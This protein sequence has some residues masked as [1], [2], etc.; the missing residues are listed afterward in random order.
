M[1]TNI[2]IR[3]IKRLTLIFY[4]RIIDSG[5]LKLKDAINIPGVIYLEY[6]CWERKRGEE[7]VK[8]E[9][10]GHKYDPALWW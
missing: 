3:K 8:I 6:N 10:Q 4:N 9:K 5:L 1:A 7:G 2:S